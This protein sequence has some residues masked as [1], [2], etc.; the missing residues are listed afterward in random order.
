MHRLLI[1]ILIA[2]FCVNADE[3][4]KC[5]VVWQSQPCGQSKIDGSRA[6]TDPISERQLRHL[7]RLA[8]RAQSALGDEPVVIEQ[9][10]SA[11]TQ[12]ELIKS[13][14]AMTLKAETLLNQQIERQ[15]RQ[16]LSAQKIVLEQQKILQRER[17]LKLDEQKI[18][19]TRRRR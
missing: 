1:I 8:N 16:R 17:K 10:R 2:P 12:V 7:A 9:A 3:I 15:S 4:F 13:C 6:Q 5:G 14:Q 19:S 11:C 18:K